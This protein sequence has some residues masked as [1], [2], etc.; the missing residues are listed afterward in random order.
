MFASD[1]VIKY[2][3]KAK[4]PYIDKVFFYKYPQITNVFGEDSFIIS[5]TLINSIP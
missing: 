3:V 2:H 5:K 1:L 4:R